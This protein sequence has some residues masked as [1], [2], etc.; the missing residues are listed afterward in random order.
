MCITTLS[1]LLVA[2]Y[3]VDGQFFGHFF[4]SLRNTV[5]LHVEGA[6]TCGG[7]SY[8]EG[9]F[10]CVKN[11]QG[12]FVCVGSSCVEGTFMCVKNM[13]RAIPVCGKLMC[14][15]DIHVCEK[16]AGI[17][18]VL[19]KL[20]CGGDIHVY[21][22]CK[23]GYSHVWKS[24][25]K[26]VYK[27]CA[28][29]CVK[30][31]WQM[32]AKNMQRTIHEWGKLMC[33]GDIHVCEKCAGLFTCVKNVCEKHVWKMCVK[34]QVKNMQKMCKNFVK[35]HVWKTCT[36]TCRGPFTCGG[37]SSVEGRATK[38][39]FFHSLI[40]FNIYLQMSITNIFN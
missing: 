29:M 5:N 20:M 24:C 6:F 23:G 30:M 22:K 25:A 32:C 26:N 15:G 17:I 31:V 27:T 18:H 35:K 1:H 11:V 39:K 38:M 37:S 10:I 16:H 12:L 28:K 4:G 7:S 14:G 21:E 3:V 2:T 36:K 40:F 8:V 34:K 19:G 13:Q 9:T 33:G